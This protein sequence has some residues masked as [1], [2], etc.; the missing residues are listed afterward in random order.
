MFEGMLQENIPYIELDNAMD[1]EHLEK[2][3]MMK[4]TVEDEASLSTAPASSSSSIPLDASDSQLL[5]SIPG[6]SFTSIKHI[7]H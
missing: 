7:S 2:Q 1:P 4:E 6:G 3:P 5:I